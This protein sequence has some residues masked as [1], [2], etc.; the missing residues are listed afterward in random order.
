MVL[1]YC[2]GLTFKGNCKQ[3]WDQIILHVVSGECVYIHDGKKPACIVIPHKYVSEDAV[4]DLV[5]LQIWVL[6]SISVDLTL[7]YLQYLLL[8]LH[9]TFEEDMLLFRLWG[10]HIM[11]L[12]VVKS[13]TL[14]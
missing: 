2:H 4:C 1:V 7:V 12:Y 13:K 9:V 14:T 6:S 11:C 3:L 10:V 8:L 5:D